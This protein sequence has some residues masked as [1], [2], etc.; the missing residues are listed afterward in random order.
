MNILLNSVPRPKDRE[1]RMGREGSNPEF[2]EIMD[3]CDL[4]KLSQ[5][6]QDEISCQ[7]NQLNRKGISDQGDHTWS[8]LLP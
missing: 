7:S 3:R 6:R 8:L 2:A 5:S 1:N 4:I